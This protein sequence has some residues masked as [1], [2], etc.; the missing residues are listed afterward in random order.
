MAEA[1]T[2]KL[3]PRPESAPP[4]SIARGERLAVALKRAHDQAPLPSKKFPRIP[5]HRAKEDYPAVA[6]VRAPIVSSRASVNNEAT[7]C[8]AYAYLSAYV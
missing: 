3:H 6:L 4:I 5:K 7:P 1:S 2:E 8:L